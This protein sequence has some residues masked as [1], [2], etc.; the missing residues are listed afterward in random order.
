MLG[1]VARRVRVNHGGQVP[2]PI[3]TIIV[4]VTAVLILGITVRTVIRVARPTKRP[5]PAALWGE[6]LKRPADPAGER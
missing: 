3:I 4:L 2:G 5:D 6:V 1:G